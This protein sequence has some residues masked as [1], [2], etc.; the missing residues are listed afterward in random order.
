MKYEVL[1]SRHDIAEHC[2]GS[3]D[4]NSEE[5]AKII[6]YKKYV[7]QPS[8]AWD[9]LRLIQVVQ[10]RIVKDIEASDPDERRKG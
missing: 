8:N 10:E 3:F 6:F 2:I 1:S 4:A 9:Y 7:G 5:E